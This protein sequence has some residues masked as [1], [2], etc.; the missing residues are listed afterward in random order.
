MFAFEFGCTVCTI[1]NTT[2]KAAEF[3]HIHLENCRLIRV[4]RS[5][6][7]GQALAAVSL[8]TVPMSAWMLQ[9]WFS[10]Q[11]D[12]IYSLKEE[13]RAEDFSLLLPGLGHGVVKL[14]P[15]LPDVK[16]GTSFSFSLL[17]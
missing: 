6:S 8:Q 15:P 2:C 5:G 1:Y 13:Q 10:S 17:N 4:S 14:R 7:Y 16:R 3:S 12:H 11:V 9:W